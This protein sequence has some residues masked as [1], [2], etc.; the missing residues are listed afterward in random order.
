MKFVALAAAA[1]LALATPSQ[2]QQGPAL[3]AFPANGETTFVQAGRLL[4]DPES[5][6][7]LRDKTLV[8]VGNQIT[9]IRDGFVGEGPN[10]VDLRD[11]FVLPGLIDSHVHLTSQQNP[12]ARIQ[13]VTRDAADSAMVGAGY[14]RLTLMAGFT[15][16]ADLGGDN[17]AVFALRDG[18]AR[19]DV[20]G[21]RVIASGSA[22]SIHG[23]H[24]D[25]NGYRDDIMHLLS[26]ESVC[27]GPEDCM[28]AVRT[29]VRSG[30]DIIKIT[31]T[32]G[33]LSNTAAGLAQQFTDAE[34]AAIVE[35]AH[36]MGR[37]VTAHAHGVD[38][39]NAFLRAGGDSIEHGTY[40]D[41]ES[42]RLFRREGVYLIPTLL[43]GDFVARVAASPTNFFTPAQT[44][45]ALEAGPKMLDMARRAHEGGVRIAFGTDTGVSAHGDNAQE[46]ALLVRA[47]LTPLEAIQAATVVAA[48]HLRIA[49]Q[50]G[51]I[52]PGRNADIVAV[53][54][55]PLTDVT[56]LEHMAFVMKGGVVYRND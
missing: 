15:T 56:T 40:L 26:S 46:F 6:V 19:G 12:N 20:P 23:G 16:V 49:D 51:L 7:V 8:I 53:A 22:V 25:I 3:Q 10:V 27:S 9:E 21:P 34:L 28:R 11:S 17:D 24:G 39:I 54:G 14:A 32:G 50:A 13:V 44:A 1:V 18:I 31:A 33:V 37:Q 2:A 36:R 30:A 48:E 41:D 43:A 35:V 47:G 52:A 5:G 4:A 42:I 29:Q 55:D 45:K 38:G